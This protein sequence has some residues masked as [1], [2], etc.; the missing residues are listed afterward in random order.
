MRTV[1]LDSTCLVAAAC[2]WHVHHEV[3]MADL[4]RRSREKHRLLTAAHAVVEAYSVL[5]RLPAAYRMPLA[6]AA[7]VLEAN[8]ARR[9][10]V[11]LTPAEYWK[12]LDVESGR[13]IGGGR[14]YDAI[15]A[16]CARKARADEI[17][18][19]NVDHFEPFAG[20]GLS[21]SRPG[22]NA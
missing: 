10:T 5:T 17:L 11:A 19:W 21:V 7:R 14:I 22:G 13:G 2:E 3:T 6:D 9:E 4:E 15:V 1:V 16:H 12:L 20:D 8:W 18:T